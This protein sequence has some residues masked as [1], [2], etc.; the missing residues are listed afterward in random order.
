MK[1]K[2]TLLKMLMLKYDDEV[3]S[4]SSFNL[5]L[6]GSPLESLTRILKFKASNRQPYHLIL[7]AKQK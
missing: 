1:L 3:G 6:P 4:R 5:G 2:A 7:N